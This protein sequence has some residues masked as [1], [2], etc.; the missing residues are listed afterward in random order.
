MV[1][2]LY[3]DKA[4]AD[5]EQIGLIQN[6]VARGLVEGQFTPQNVKMSFVKTDQV[7]EKFKNA[8][9]KAKN[10]QYLDDAEMVL[11]FQSPKTAPAPE[12]DDGEENPAPEDA[13][14]KE[15]PAEEA[16]EETVSE[17]V[18]VQDLSKSVGLKT[19]GSKSCSCGKKTCCCGTKKTVKEEEAPKKKSAKKDPPKTVK[20]KKD[21]EKPAE[22]DREEVVDEAEM[23]A[24][25]D[26]LK[27][28]VSDAIKRVLYLPKDEEVE[29]ITL[30]DF[31]DGYDTFF[32]KLSF[33][34]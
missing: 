15:A 21:L 22:K 8:V 5:K 33:K 17:S 2:Q 28:K 12:Q 14:E 1:I 6:L 13:P 9:K 11:V 27:A 24:T 19:V 23:T 3:S 18:K 30:E 7:G 31:R 10:A 34:E 20:S 26:E 25:G 4:P 32:T 16:P 29:M